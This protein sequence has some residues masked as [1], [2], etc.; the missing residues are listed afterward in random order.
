VEDRKGD[1]RASDPWR[2]QAGERPSRGS[3]TAVRTFLIADVRG[4]TRFT[5]EHGDEEAGQLAARFAELARETVFSAGGEVIE[6]RG[7][8]ALSVFGSARQ[9]LRAAVELQVRFR[10]PTDDG[11]AFQLP[12]GIGLDAGEAVPIEGGYRGGAL[13]TA[14]RLCSLA[15]PGQIL[16]TD[17]VVSLARRLEGIRFV[18]RR[19]VRVKGLEK[20]VRVVEVVPEA[21]LPQLPELP[22]TKRPLVTRRRA[23]AVAAIGTALVAALVGLVLVR[24]RGPEFLPRL[25]ANAIGVIDADAAGIAEQL[26]LGTKPSAI[27]AGGDRLWVASEEDGTVSR[28]HPDTRDVQTLTVGGGAGGVAYG[29]GSVWVTNVEERA[30]VQ[31]DPESMRVGQTIA[32][33]NAP[34]AVA[35]G[36]GAVWVANTL[37]GTV[38]RLDL[39]RGAVKTISVRESPAGIAVGANAVWVTSEASGLV[40]RLDPRSGTG[41]EAINVGNG[42]TAVAV[43]EGAV[44][45]ANRQD[46]T[47]SRIDPATN[48]VSATIRVGTNPSAV[49]AAQGSVWVANTGGGTIA[50]IDPRVDR[51]DK[52]IPTTSG[53]NALALADGDVWTT[54]LPSLASHRGGVLRVQSV[55]IECRCIDPAFVTG[56]TE[57]QYVIPLLHDGLVAYRRVG[58][59]GGGA[60]VGNLAVRVPTPTD[61][62]RTYVFQLRRGTRYSDGSPVLASDFRYSLE[63]QLTLDRMISPGYFG[64][65]VGASQCSAEPPERCDLS[66]GIEVDDRTGRIAIHLTEADSDFLYKLTLPYASIIPTGTPL[67]PARDRP[68]PTT[69]A[70]GIESFD[71]P[72]E[73]RLVRNPYFR[74]WSPDARPDGYPNEIRFQLTEDVDA[75]VAAV[76]RGEADCVCAT[77]IPIERLPGLLTR[78]PGRVHSDAAP[79]TDY[80]FLNTRVPPFNDRRVRQALNYAADRRK[81]AEL[82]GGTLAARPTC[83]ILP[84]AIPGYR[85]YCPYTLDPNPA[86]TWT[87]P[88]LAR[89]RALVAASGTQGMRVE[90]L[91]GET[92]GSAVFS[93]LIV[94]ALRQLGYRSSLRVLPPNDYY[95]FV[96]NSRNRGQI[97]PI[98][99]YADAAPALF[100]RDLFS[101][102]SFLPG[103]SGNVNFSA[104]CDGAIDR[105]MRRAAALQTSD[106]V[107][108]NG[109][110][111][112]VSRALVDEAAAV[113]LLN[114]RPVSFVSERVGNYQFHPQWGPLFDQMW[115]K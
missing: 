60:L 49:A 80:M 74:V 5:Q 94:A 114:Q 72:R 4:Y 92:F 8:E 9:A 83:Q 103:N 22:V 101:C 33:G 21:G 48:A 77:G 27:A 1:S 6:L 36:E 42:P 99:W 88:D 10:S 100:L 63:R 28:I 85:P 86:G 89:A 104:F 61:E 69:G 78:Y 76:E 67:R 11:P 23:V 90:V 15:G 25:D 68:I 112:D 13:N 34:R 30:V 19:P 46:G 57:L 108:A 51:V 50:R 81:M 95:P 3:D 45:V 18:D 107:R 55:P 32:V 20:P 96:A 70:Y 71:T 43:G 24:A 73:L 26:S 87:A 14:A 38:S 102:A 93:R 66:R 16:A 17:T 41:V 98:A 65:I 115:V 54:T 52:T 35:V 109:L 105:T 110:W 82:R 64:G 58:G 31:I 53:P 2:T 12:I 75:Q 29:A 59:I 97:G 113:P 79:M 91:A 62:G 111:A 47:V 37:D 44:W 40:L 106:P 39:L 84:P 7:D 56:F